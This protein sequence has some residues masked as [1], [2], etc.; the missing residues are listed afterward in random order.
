MGLTPEQQRLD[1]ISEAIGRLLKKQDELEQ[2]IARLEGKE[3][4]AERPAPPV[5]PVLSQPPAVPLEPETI[6]PAKPA[7]P[8]TPKKAALETKLG[9]TVINRI[10]VITLV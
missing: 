1:I 10:G 3:P 5:E 9:L 7:L 4:A 8:P 2:R 6:L